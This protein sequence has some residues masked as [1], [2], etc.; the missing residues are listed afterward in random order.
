[1]AASPACGTSSPAP[2]SPRCPPARTPRRWTAPQNP[3]AKA[4]AASRNG[5]PGVAAPGLGDPW[6]QLWNVRQCGPSR[7]RIVMR[8]VADMTVRVLPPG[9]VARRRGRARP[10]RSAQLAP[11]SRPLAVGLFQAAT[12]TRDRV[13]FTR[14]QRVRDRPGPRGEDVP[15]VRRHCGRPAPGAWFPRQWRR[16][17]R[18]AA[19]ARATHGHRPRRVRRAGPG[20]AAWPSASSSSFGGG[21]WRHSARRGPAAVTLPRGL[22]RGVRRR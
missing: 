8:L 3:A 6:V 1:M 7:D 18:Q 4:S 11:N 13:P 2:R 20:C 17:E 9:R 14:R 15:V 16:T 19:L 12:G 10:S 5:W 21:L 22:F